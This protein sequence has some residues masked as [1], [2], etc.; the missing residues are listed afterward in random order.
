VGGIVAQET[1]RPLESAPN[2]QRPAGSDQE[3]LDEKQVPQQPEPS[4]PNPQIH[5]PVLGTPNE[6]ALV[7]DLEYYEPEPGFN[8]QDRNIDLQVARAAL[9]AHFRQGWEFQFDVLAIRA[10]GTA[11]LSSTPPIPFAGAKQCPRRGSGTSR[12][13]ERHAIQPLAPICGCSGGF[14]S[15]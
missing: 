8:R 5:I 3:T 6:I 9:A 13:L 12:A 2:T 11:V 1:S 4:Q 14:D 10:R 15:Q 7:T